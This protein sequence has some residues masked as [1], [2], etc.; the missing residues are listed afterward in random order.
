[1]PSAS[2]HKRAETINY[3]TATKRTA[4]MH[5]EICRE[6]KIEFFSDTPQAIMLSAK[7]RKWSASIRIDHY[8]R[9]IYQWSRIYVGEQ[10]GETFPVYRWCY[11]TSRPTKPRLCHFHRDSATFFV[12][13]FSVVLAINLRERKRETAISRR[14]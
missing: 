12:H 2:A 13:I 4:S 5:E 3:L 6:S 9:Y 10:T 14:L 11:I 8:R 1:M 7:Q